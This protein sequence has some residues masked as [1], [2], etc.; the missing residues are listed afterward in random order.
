MLF[1]QLCQGFVLYAEQGPDIQAFLKNVYSFSEFPQPIHPLANHFF[2]TVSST[3]LSYCFCV[4]FLRS[5]GRSPAHSRKRVIGAGCKLLDKDG[6]ATPAKHKH[7]ISLNSMV[8][9]GSPS[10]KT[11]FPR[12]RPLPRLSIENPPVPRGS[13]R[14]DRKG[15]TR[16][17]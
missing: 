4:F 11:L 2:I 14:W 7:G 8:L 5:I 16:A 9:S 17:R 12:N 13:D 6:E 15:T 10:R 1:L 3:L